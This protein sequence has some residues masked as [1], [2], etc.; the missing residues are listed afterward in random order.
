MINSTKAPLFLYI[1][2]RIIK[3]SEDVFTDFMQRNF[4]KSPN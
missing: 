3:K 1:P 2:A 4:N